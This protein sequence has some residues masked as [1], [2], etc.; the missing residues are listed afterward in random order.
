MKTLAPD[1]ET[2]TAL[3]QEIVRAREKF[4]GSRYLFAALLEEVGETAEEL[5]T[6]NASGLLGKELLQIA[7]VA[8][9]IYEEQREVLLD[10][11]S[12]GQL[13]LC[14]ARFGELARNLLQRRSIGAAVFSLR[15]SAWTLAVDGDPTFASITD[16]EAKS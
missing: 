16:D 10:P 11:S 1:E 6:K 7:C 13:T 14:A 4:P 3:S 2:L 8:I 9:R 12:R 5:L 15:S